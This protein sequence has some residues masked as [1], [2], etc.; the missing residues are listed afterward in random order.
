MQ[1]EGQMQ[2]GLT[3]KLCTTVSCIPKQEPLHPGVQQLYV[4]PDDFAVLPAVHHIDRV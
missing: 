2:P 1:M 4:I 3:I